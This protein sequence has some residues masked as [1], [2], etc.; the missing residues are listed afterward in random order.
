[1]QESIRLGISFNRHCGADGRQ[2]LGVNR[3]TQQANSHS[4]S[5]GAHSNFTDFRGDIGCGL[6][7]DVGHSDKA[8]GVS[9]QLVSGYV[10]K[11]IT[12]YRWTLD[13]LPGFLC[14]AG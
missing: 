8:Y 3:C 14:F 5:E 10:P 9:G 2:A 11:S 1:V 4:L 7:T 6:I 13:G 12:S